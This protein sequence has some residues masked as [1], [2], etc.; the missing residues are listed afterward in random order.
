M[1]NTVC[2]DNIS[3]DKT[4]TPKTVFKAS[5]TAFAWLSIFFGYLFCR[6]FPSDINP[7]GG[8]LFILFLF[9]VTSAVLK[10]KKIKIYKYALIA[11]VSA[12][13]ISFSLLLTSNAVINNVAYFYSLIAYLY[14]VYAAFGNSVEK[15]FSNFI[16]ADIFKAAFVLPF[17]SVAKSVGAL[18]PPKFKN[19]KKTA[20]KILIGIAVAVIPTTVVFFLLSYD[21]EFIRIISDIFDFG[22]DEKIGRAHV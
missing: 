22:W 21:S 18:F 5:D 13:L 11:A 2:N 17:C 19:G 3:N 10:I 7:F 20:L 8:F 4:K 6:V 16:T 12:I 14:F 1:E 9:S 15:G